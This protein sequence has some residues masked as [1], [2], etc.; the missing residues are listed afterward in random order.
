MRTKKAFLLKT[1]R[2]TKFAPFLCRCSDCKK[3]FTAQSLRNACTTFVARLAGVNIG[4]L[5]GC[6]ANML[7]G[8]KA[9]FPLPEKLSAASKAALRA[10]MSLRFDQLPPGVPAADNPGHE[11]CS[12]P[13]A[14]G[15]GS[16]TS[17]ESETDDEGLG[18]MHPVVA[19]SDE[20]KKHIRAT[21]DM[22]H[23]IKLSQEH[24]FEHHGSCFKRNNKKHQC[25]GFKVSRFELSQFGPQSSTVAISG[26]FGAATPAWG[27]VFFNKIK[28]DT[29]FD[30]AVRNLGH[31][32]VIG[33]RYLWNALRAVVWFCL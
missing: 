3:K 4:G 18:V 25:K 23:A 5:H 6:V 13:T 24:K 22:T 9:G 16:S 28:S 33:R 12:R 21:I 15:G 32:G 19:L 7:S 1:N 17:S 11:A 27:L 29:H 30:S 26:Y 20:I 8:S 31:A 2:M 10:A 14:C